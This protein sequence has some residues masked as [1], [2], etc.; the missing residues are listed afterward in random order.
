VVFHAWLPF[1]CGTGFS[2]YL[3]YLDESGD[4]GAWTTGAQNHF[5]IGGVAVHEGK[6]REYS[7]KLDAIQ[8]KFFPKIQVPIAFHASE[9]RNGKDRFR[10]LS[11]AD[12]AVLLDDLYEVLH[13][14]R[15]PNLIAFATVMHISAVQ[16]S[17]QVLHDTFED[18]CQRFNTFLVR[19]YKAGFIDKGLLIIDQAHQ[20]RY[21]HLVADFHEHGTAYGYLGNI[22]DIPYFSGRRDTR[23]LQIADLCAS[24]V[25]QHYEHRDSGCFRKMYI[26]LDRRARGK[27]AEG[28]KHLTRVPCTCEACS[29]R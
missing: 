11:P 26:C 27:P 25:Y 17:D 29:W 9:I 19:Q 22:V 4:P 6:I 7:E 12:R 1:L 18:V 10:E 20:D 15:F 2:L 13:Q 28:L 21:R 8:A 16:N 24:A 3:L 14:A 5:V 23:M